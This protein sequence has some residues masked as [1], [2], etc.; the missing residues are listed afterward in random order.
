[1][2]GCVSPWALSPPLLL[3]SAPQ[4]ALRPANTCMNLH[5]PRCGQILPNS[6]W[7]VRRSVCHAMNDLLS[8]R[9]FQILA[10]RPSSSK[11]GP[12]A[13]QQQLVPAV[14]YIECDLSKV[15]VALP[16]HNLVWPSKY[17][18]RQQC[19][20]QGLLLRQCVESIC[21]MMM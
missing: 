7:A 11:I 9:R 4:H 2:S 3:H 12:L 16:Q 8:I 5:H 20:S 6:T 18:L 10:K 1:M 13:R 14:L 15:G 17:M 21:P 19:T